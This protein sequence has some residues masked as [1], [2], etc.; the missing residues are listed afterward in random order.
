MPTIVTN[1][2]FSDESR[3][4]IR[5]VMDRITDHISNP[6]QKGYV[7]IYGS[8]EESL[9]RLS[10]AAMSGMVFPDLVSQYAPRFEESHIAVGYE[11]LER[12]FTAAMSWDLVSSLVSALARD[13]G[14]M[15]RVF[16]S[17]RVCV[18]DSILD[19]MH[20]VDPVAHLLCIGTMRRVVVDTRV[21]S[22]SNLDFTMML[23]AAAHAMRHLGQ[24]VL[25]GRGNAD[26]SLRHMG[27]ERLLLFGNLP[28]YLNAYFGLTR[29]IDAEAF[30]MST[31]LEFMTELFGEDCARQLMFYYNHIRMAE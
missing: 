15:V 5:S 30:A 20:A 18:G 9:N 6:D 2:A 16:P 12:R 21:D 17:G 4:S 26:P 14:V 27:A 31:C 25:V 11:A 19:D 10:M 1:S 7:P 13:M 8:D 3:A 29:E 28:A 23:I 24:A 22:Y